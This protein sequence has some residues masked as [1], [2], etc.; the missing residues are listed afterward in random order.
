[1]PEPTVTTTPDRPRFRQVVLWALFTGVLVLGL[2]LYFQ[3]AGRIA[4]LIDATGDR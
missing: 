4:P 3:Y 2:V 1:M